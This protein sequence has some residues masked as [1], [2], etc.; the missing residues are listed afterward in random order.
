MELSSLST[1]TNF[2][3]LNETLS[4]NLLINISHDINPQ[5]FAWLYDGHNIENPRISTEEHQLTIQQ[6]QPSDAGYYSA[7]TTNNL[8]CISTNF[9]LAVVCE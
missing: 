9:K 4:S 3:L 7:V 6:V 1:D 5:Q 2:T 8:Q